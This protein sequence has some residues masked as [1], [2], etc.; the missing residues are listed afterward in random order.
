MFY[1]GK[2]PNYCYY[3]T[4]GS[5]IVYKTLCFALEAKALALKQGI[6]L[7]V[8][9]FLP[10]FH[11]V[12]AKICTYMYMDKL[13]LHWGTDSVTELP[14]KW[15]S[16]SLVKHEQEDNLIGYWNMPAFLYPDLQSNGRNR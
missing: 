14:S 5:A 6:D 10:Y 1:N 12:L 8:L 16:C 15:F 3:M 9:Y 11:I 13:I 4:T 7:C 2:G